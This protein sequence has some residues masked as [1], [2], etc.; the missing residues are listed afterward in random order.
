MRHGIRHA[1]ESHVDHV[2]AQLATAPR[3]DPMSQ[4]T[5]DNHD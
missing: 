2:T 5:T 4:A 1:V 3:I